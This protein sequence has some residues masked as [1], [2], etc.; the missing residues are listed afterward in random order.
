MKIWQHLS[1]EP[2]G[3]EGKALQYQQTQSQK[4]K[5][6]PYDDSCPQHLFRHPSF[7]RRL[8]ILI[9]KTY[10]VYVDDDTKHVVIVLD[11]RQGENQGRA[12]NKLQSD[13]Q[14]RDSNC[15]RPGINDCWYGVLTPMLLALMRTN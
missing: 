10:L 11:F 15:P 4:P 5:R 1:S 14:E 6:V 13:Q 12:Q 8:T 2:L 3:S 7:N 9:P